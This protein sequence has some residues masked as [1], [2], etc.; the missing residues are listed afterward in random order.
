MPVCMRF[1][2]LYPRSMLVLMVLVMGMGMALLQGV[3]AMLMPLRQMKPHAKAH[4]QGCEP[5]R[6]ACNFTKNNQSHGRSDEGSSRKVSPS[7][8]CT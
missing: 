4:Q 2:N 7:A 8:S 3:V 5:E 1:P 6:C